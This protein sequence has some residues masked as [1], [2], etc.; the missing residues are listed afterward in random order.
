MEFF[1]SQIAGAMIAAVLARLI[2]MRVKQ[3][4]EEEVSEQAQKFFGPAT[5]F[6]PCEDDPKPRPAGSGARRPR[7]ESPERGG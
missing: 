5:Q 6:K 1:I 2:V 4:V 3:G 7:R